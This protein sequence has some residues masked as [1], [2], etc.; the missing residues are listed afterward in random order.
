[1]S[2]NSEDQVR[3]QIYE[4]LIVLIMFDIFND[5]FEI[6]YYVHFIII[7]DFYII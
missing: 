2:D 7:I 1:M 5:K 4:Y 6:Y 3:L